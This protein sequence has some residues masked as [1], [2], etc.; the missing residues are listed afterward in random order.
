MCLI[1]YL[2]LPFLLLVG[3][4]RFS[5]G[6]G[7]WRWMQVPAPISKLTPCTALGKSVLPSGMTYLLPLICDQESLCSHFTI[8]RSINLAQ[9]G[10]TTTVHLYSPWK[11]K[12]IN[13]CSHNISAYGISLLTSLVSPLLV[14]LCCF[15]R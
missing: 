11:G 5:A 12:M 9:E 6:E 2:F 1:K 4:Y 13:G 7:G 3:L 14:V 15:F 10:M 8:C